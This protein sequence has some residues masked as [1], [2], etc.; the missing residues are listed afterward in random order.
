MKL[1]LGMTLLTLIAGTNSQFIP[2]DEDIAC[3]GQYIIENLEDE[4]VLN[5]IN[6]CP[7]DIT[8]QEDACSNEDCL[9]GLAT[10][11]SRCDS[12]YD[13]RARKQMWQIN[14]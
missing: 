12:D 11:Y 14:T 13:V 3:V 9:S 5:V 8:N 7:Q 2:S 10:L 6:D 4:A 1:L